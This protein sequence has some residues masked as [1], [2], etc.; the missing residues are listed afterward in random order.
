[1]SPTAPK[2]LILNAER[3]VEIFRDTVE[4]VHVR[5]ADF[6]AVECCLREIID[7]LYDR[8]L[9]SGALRA[10]VDECLDM[11]KDMPGVSPGALVLME[12]ALLHLAGSLVQHLDNA[13]V[14]DQ[15]GHMPYLYYGLTGYAVMLEYFPF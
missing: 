1:M 15:Y 4:T 13:G 6:D 2:F 12:T 7:Q 3:E 11:L 5:F 8:Q 10:Y 14:Y 9:R